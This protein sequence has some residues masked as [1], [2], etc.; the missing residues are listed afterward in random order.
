MLDLYSYL[1]M[2]RVERKSLKPKVKIVKKKPNNE[3]NE[4][5]WNYLLKNDTE[6][7]AYQKFHYHAFLPKPN[8]KEVDSNEG[9]IA[10]YEAQ[11]RFMQYKN[12]MHLPNTPVRHLDLTSA[13]ATVLSGINKSITFFMKHKYATFDKISNCFKDD[14]FY[15]VNIKAR[16]LYDPIINLYAPN[17]KIRFNNKPISVYNMPS[18][19]DVVYMDAK[20]LYSKALNIYGFKYFVDDVYNNL[21]DIVE[22]DITILAY[23][24]VKRPKIY[25][26]DHLH[27]LL[28]ETKQ[29]VDRQTRIDTK[30]ALVT[31]TGL[32]L[33]V[34][35]GMRLIMLGKTEEII[36]RF[37]L[38]L[39]EKGA[40][41][42]GVQI[43]AIYYIG[44]D[45]S[46]Q[47]MMSVINQVTGIDVFNY[48]IDA[49]VKLEN[50][51][52]KDYKETPFRLQEV[53]NE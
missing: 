4:M 9:A 26:Y 14:L 20:L 50:Y 21:I 24:I 1:N 47:Y 45:L 52:S 3:L 40:E 33:H 13:Y 22:H 46:N 31:F 6:Y 32:L 19:G 44:P 35:P 12:P 25:T 28:V 49:F 11:R 8:P 41:V 7:N 27:Q 15:I 10:I 43:D 39:I 53:H 30:I 38:K 36:H 34:D 23:N 18:L 51:T 16:V 42:E 17:T 37:R 29:E 5:I 48:G 2:R